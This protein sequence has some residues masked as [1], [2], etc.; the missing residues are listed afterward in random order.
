MKLESYRQRNGF[1]AGTNVEKLPDNAGDIRDIISI[2]ELR[3]STGGGLGYPLQ[4]S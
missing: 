2:S 1:P 4:Y 3:K